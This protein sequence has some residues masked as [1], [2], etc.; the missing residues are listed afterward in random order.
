M[1]LSP[2]VIETI[3]Q[4]GRYHD[5][6]GLHLKVT[7]TGSK[8]WIVRYQIHG[9]RHDVGLGSYPAV[10]LTEARKRTVAMRAQINSGID[11]KEKRPSESPI[12]EQEA[13]NYIERH[14]AGWS[15]KHASQWE[16]S[17][18]E[19]VFPTMGPLLVNAVSTADVVRV[20][21]PIWADKPETARRIRNR[22]WN[23]LEYSTA[24]G[25][26]QGDNPAKWKGHI[27][28][29]MGRRRDDTVPLESMPY[30]QLPHFM[31]QLDSIGTRQ[32]LCLMFIILTAS[33]S[34]EAM[35]AKWSE[36]DFTRKVWTIPPER[37]KGK[38]EHQVPLSDPA[39]QVLADVGTRGKSDFIFPN[40]RLSGLLAEN[41]LRRL[42][43]KMNEECTVHGFRA[44]FRTWAAEKTNFDF[45]VCEKA[46]SHTVGNATS[47][48]Y[49]RGSQIEKRRALMDRWAKYAM[50]K[51]LP[52]VR[53]HRP[54]NQASA[55]A[56]L[57]F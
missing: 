1:A 25:H 13:L 17:L 11:P 3:T 42:L 36:I 46:L 23:V 21:D 50:E 24:L 18:R 28:N 27:E 6:H 45:D 41:A 10:S 5:K 57:V 29:L 30:L 22:I 43:K 26:R 51:L 16:N 2:K 37:M 44:T 47:R 38:K 19:H 55:M 31:R 32:S 8:S 4:A 33:R 48:A 39:M 9:K 35:E 53:E 15:A 12:F 40:K 49:S 54:F 34:S 56:S 20:L 14:R 7:P 52:E